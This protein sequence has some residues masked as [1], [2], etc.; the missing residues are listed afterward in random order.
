MPT[1]SGVQTII[2]SRHRHACNKN[3]SFIQA[4]FKH[5]VQQHK[6][7]KLLSSVPHY[8]SLLDQSS[9]PKQTNFRN[10]QNISEIT[11][12]YGKKKGGRTMNLHKKTSE[13]PSLNPH[14]YPILEHK[15]LKARKHITHS[16]SADLLTHPFIYLT[17]QTQ[18]ST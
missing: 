14:Y 12:I 9:Y 17:K 8:P 6:Q 5:E 1:V 16:F 10:L 11:I 18:N 7:M 4:H 13:I 3:F 15:M 2:G